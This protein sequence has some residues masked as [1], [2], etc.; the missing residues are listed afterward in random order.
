MSESVLDHGYVPEEHAPDPVIGH[1]DPTPP[2]K[3]AIWMFLASEIMFFIAILATYIILRSGQPELFKKFA[4]V[5]SK[6][7]GAINTLVLILSSLTMA[8]AVDASQKGK[9]N[10]TVVYLLITFLC[11]SAFMVVKVGIE[12]ADKWN[13]HTIV[14]RDSSSTSGFSVVDGHFDAAKSDAAT[15]VLNGA[16]MAIP[17]HGQFDI[18]L[19]GEEDIVKKGIVTANANGNETTRA[20]GF[21]GEISVARSAI[22]QDINYMPWKNMFYACYFTLTGIHGIHV[23]G[24]MVALFILMVQALRGKLL[25][26]HTEYIGLY[27]HFVD[28]VWIFLF[29]LLYLI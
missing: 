4:S 10:K 22:A 5:L 6:P 2:G 14:Y 25:P 21:E 3:V 1:G 26:A 19:V 24:G 18:H 29:P 12:Y 20:E 27:W 16:K 8:L 17:T 15:I 13:H 9:R 7:I 28:L 11:A 23:L